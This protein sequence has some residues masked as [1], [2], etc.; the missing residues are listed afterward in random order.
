MTAEKHAWLAERGLDTGQHACPI[1]GNVHQPDPSDAA[2]APAAV[3]V[4]T[5]TE[6]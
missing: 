5:P 1:C 6:E 2:A 3:T 4:S